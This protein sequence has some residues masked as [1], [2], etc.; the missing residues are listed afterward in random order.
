MDYKT[1]PL[2]R[3]KIRVL[4]QYFRN[5]FDVPASGPFPVLEALEKVPDVFKGSNYEIVEDH[6]LDPRVMAQCSPNNDG[7]FTIKIKASVYDGAYEN[8]TGAFLG[9]IN[10]E[11]CHLFLFEIGFTPIYER[12]FANNTIPAY[13]SVE[14]QAKALNGE[15][16]LPYEECKNMSENDIEKKFNVSK[17]SISYFKSNIAKGSDNHEGKEKTHW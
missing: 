3:K 2:T 5:L 8:N 12:S 13:Q 15:V 10:H 9:F 11:I 7:G 16:M 17:S 1:K 4:A 14:W 6:Q